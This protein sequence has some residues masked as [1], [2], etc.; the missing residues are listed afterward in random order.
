[1]KKETL[2]LKIALG[3]LCIP[4]ILLAFIGLPLLIREALGAFPKQ[5]ALIYIAFGSIYLSAIPFFTVIFQAFKL[6]LL[7]DKKEAF[8]KSAV[9]KLMIIKVSAFI[10]SG[11]YVF[12]L[13]LFYMAAEYDDAPGV[14]IVGLIVIF[15]AFVIAIFA[16][17][18]EK[19]LANAILIKSE[20]D[21][22][23]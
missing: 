19:L 13:P 2:F 4:V 23:I 12:T 16:A 6:L 20:N 15:A 1:M 7:I 17:V 11:L 8:S 10:I 18:L 3:I 5:L 22:T 21:L 9:H 14:I